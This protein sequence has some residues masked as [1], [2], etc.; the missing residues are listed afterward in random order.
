MN[1]RT[2]LQENEVD[3][4]I[5]L[6]KVYA[7]G[8]QQKHPQQSRRDEVADIVL[9]EVLDLN[10]REILTSS[11]ERLLGQLAVIAFRNT[12]DAEHISLPNF[13]RSMPI[14][15]TRLPRQRKLGDEQ[16]NRRLYS[17]RIK[18]GKKWLDHL[19]GDFNDELISNLFLN[20][21]VEQAASAVKK[22]YNNNQR[23]NPKDS[24]SLKGFAGMSDQQY[25]KFSRG[26]FY[27]TGIRILAPIL[28]VT[29]LRKAKAKDDYTTMR[30]SVVDMTRV[31]K[32]DGGHISRAI[33]VGVMTV[34]PFE[35]VLNSTYTLLGQG[36]L[37]PSKRRFRSPFKL[38]DHIRD[39]IL[40]KFGADKGGGSWKLI[41]NPVNVENPQSVRHVQPICEFT[42]ND[43][44]KHMSAL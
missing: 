28:D 9:E 4:M 11:E 39:V 7:K 3:L 42:A 2:Y 44:H 13:P 8:V 38:E 35:C 32:K 30:R 5:S 29:R 33:K 43:S 23:L 21:G 14:K 16:Q 22:Y 15:I 25:V 36:K 6:L 40:W 12:D 31:T 27:F 17:A 24:S 37:L 26:F 41:G 19:P 10:S 20:I 34:R 1:E 18:T